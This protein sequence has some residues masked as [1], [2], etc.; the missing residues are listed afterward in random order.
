MIPHRLF[1]LLAL[2]VVVGALAQPLAACGKRG[3]PQPPGGTPDGY[4]RHYPVS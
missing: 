1:R 2:A 4:P 3:T